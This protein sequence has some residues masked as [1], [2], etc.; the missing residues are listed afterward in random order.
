[1]NTAHLG[2]F[3]Y[4]RITHRLTV[5]GGFGAWVGGGLELRTPN[6]IKTARPAWVH[7]KHKKQQGREKQTKNAPFGAF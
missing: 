1:M 2:G 7:A 3:F 6:K 4:S 5:F